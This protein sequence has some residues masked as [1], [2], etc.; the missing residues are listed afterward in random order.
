MWPIVKVNSTEVRICYCSFLLLH[1]EECVSAFY[2]SLFLKGKTAIM[3]QEWSPNTGKVTCNVHLL[4][5][6]CVQIN[7]SLWKPGKCYTAKGELYI[8]A[9]NVPCPVEHIKSNGVEERTC[10]TCTEC[11]KKT[12]GHLQ[13]HVMWCAVYYPH[14][15]HCKLL[16]QHVNH[17]EVQHWTACH[18]LPAM[19]SS[20]IRVLAKGHGLRSSPVH[21]AYHNVLSSTSGTRCRGTP[22]VSCSSTFEPC[23]SSWDSMFISVST[24]YASCY[25]T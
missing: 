3:R 4:K 25:N 2:T 23:S 7:Q 12:I 17:N 24:P 20:F 13:R 22:T 15:L 1:C 8:M 6:L 10:H 11:S 21:L 19:F 16:W 18:A 5:S 14:R 9:S